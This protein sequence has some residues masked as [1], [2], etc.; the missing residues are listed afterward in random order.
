MS[1]E[2]D[3]A[4]DPALLPAM[5]APATTALLVIDVQVDFVAPSG[6]VG[7]S[8]VDLTKMAAPLERIETLM[9]VARNAGVTVVLT[10]VVTR[11][12]TDT[13]AQK[14]FR[15]RKGHPPSSSDICRA[16]TDGVGYY[17]ITPVAGDIEIEKPNYSSFVGTDLADRLRQRGI[18]TLVLCGFTTECCIDCTARDAFHLDFNVFVVM[19][20]CAAYSDDLHLGALNALSNNCALLTDTNG[21]ST[22]WT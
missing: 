10:R 6:A 22:A 15:Q 3:P 4:V 13:N 18:D 1:I 7:R 19:D 16:G 9:R 11:P 14:L 12:E 20:A 5:I 8:G 2:L 17:R 21:V